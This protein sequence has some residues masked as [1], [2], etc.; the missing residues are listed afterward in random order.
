[1]GFIESIRSCFSKFFTFTGRAARPEFWWFVLFAFVTN[2]VL[3]LLDELV[4][5]L[6]GQT[7]L[8]G[9]PLSGIFSLVVFFP[10]LAVAWRRLH[11]TGRPGWLALVPV[12][13]NILGMVGVFS[14][15]LAFATLEKAGAES[16]TL[17]S[18]AT[19]LGVNGILLVLAAQ[20]VMTVLLIWWCSR[21]GEPGGNAWGAPPLR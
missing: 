9:S 3:T 6:P 10:L 11:D 7:L 16:D 15:I 4:F 17:L 12:G 13:L 18:L 20:F 21:P 14:G 19:F 1:M 8:L 2:T 5:N